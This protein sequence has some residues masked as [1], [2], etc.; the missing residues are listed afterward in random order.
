MGAAGELRLVVET[1]VCDPVLDMA[2]GHALMDRAA[3]GATPPTVR[4]SRPGPAVAFGR[5]DV[6]TPGYAEAVAAARAAGFEG[7]ERVAGGRASVFHG[8]T[9]HVGHAVAD[10]DARAGIAERFERT[11]TLFARAFGGLGIDARVGAVDGEYCPGEHSVNARGA[12]KL[13]GLAQ[14]VVS[15]G[16]YVGAVVVVSDAALV[17]D[18]LAPVYAALGLDWRPEATGALA[19]EAPG[20]DPRAVAGALADAYADELAAEPGAL[21]AETRA[22]ARRLVPEHRSPDGT[23]AVR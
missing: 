12:V 8:G 22:L 7:V 3:A 9:V 2:I 21:D 6:V 20:L 18:V 10:P 16:A 14:R 5:R 17:R 13:M 11:A 1:E 4:I 23:S 15:G 19:D